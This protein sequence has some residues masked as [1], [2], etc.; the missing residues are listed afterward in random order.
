MDLRSSA[1][2]A[3]VAHYARRVELRDVLE[4]LGALERHG[5]RYAVFGGLAMAA[6]GLDRATRDLDLFVAPDDDN[7]RRLRAALHDVYD[8]AS[9]DDITA[10]DLAG[11]YPAIQYGPPGVDYTIDVVSR[12]GNAFTFDDLEVERVR[13]GD[14]ELAVVSV[15]TLYA[16]KRDTVR[17]RDRDDAERLR[18]RF[19]LEDP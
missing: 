16:M 6:H 2:A 18:R 19:S 14:L 10:A 15:R 7:V 9:I 11:D 5:V 1:V 12:L 3:D 17:A 4:V 13:A 8:D